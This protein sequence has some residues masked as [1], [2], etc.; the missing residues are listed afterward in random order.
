[1]RTFWGD[2]YE[3]MPRGGRVRLHVSISS[4]RARTLVMCAAFGLLVF[5]SAEVAAAPNLTFKDRL[6]AQ[7]T[8]ER[9][10]HAHMLG[11]PSS[12]HEIYPPTLTE[13]R[14]RDYLR[15]S[16][17]LQSYWG[18]PVDA[19][20]LEREMERIAGATRMPER[21]EEVYTALGNN[22]VLIQE[23]FIR[24]LV[25][26]RLARSFF[27]RDR[28]IHAEEL[29]T[30]EALRSRLLDGSIDP[31]T[32]R[33]DR[34]LIELNLASEPSSAPG[35]STDEEMP[36][37]EESGAWRIHLDNDAFAER[38]AQFVMPEGAPGPIE[39]SDESFVVRVVLER[40][41]DH[42]LVAVYT[43]AKRSWDDW[44]TEVA[45]GLDEKGVGVAAAPYAT[46]IRPYSVPHPEQGASAPA[47]DAP[48]DNIWDN[49][50][51][52][53][54][55]SGRRLNVAVWTGTYLIVWGGFGTQ[56]IRADGARYDPATDTWSQISQVGAPGARAQFSAVWSGREMIIW[57]GIGS[58]F[59]SSFLNSGGRYDPQTD[60]WRPTQLAGA[61]S[62]RRYQSAV[63]TGDRMIVWGGG[64]G[65]DNRL[66]SGG[67]YDPVADAWTPTTLT[68]APEGRLWHSAVW[69][70]TEMMVWGGVGNGLLRYGMDTGGLYN[71]TTNTWR[72]TSVEGAP[73][74]RY[75]H[76]AVWSGSRVLIWG[77]DG[78]FRSGGRYDP[79]R[80]LWEP[81]S[82]DDAPDGSA[83]HSAVWVG[84]A[85][86]VWGASYGSNAGARYDVD[87][88]RWSPISDE[89]APM[90]RGGHAAVWTGSLMLIWGGENIWS[91]LDTGGRYDPKADSWTPISTA[92]N[93]P[94]RSRYSAVWTG[95]EMIIW[96][97]RTADAHYT[98]TGHRY[99][100]ISDI[101]T[102]IA[103][104]GAPS[105]RAG[106]GAVWIGDSMVVW[107]G[108]GSNPIEAG[109][110]Y[111]P[112]SDRWIPVS[113]VGAPVSSLVTSLF[114]TGKEMI[115]WGTLYDQSGSAGGLYSPSTDTWRS[116]SSDGGPSALVSPSTVWTGHD[117]L[118]WGRD[119]NSLDPHGWSYHLNSD[120][121]RPMSETDQPST[122]VVATSIWTG[123]EMVIW[124]GDAYGGT[125]PLDTGA[126]YDPHTDHWRP[127]STTSAPSARTSP[128]AVWTGRR[129]MVW[130]GSNRGLLNTGGLYDPKTDTWTA[131]A[132]LDAPTG[133]G[134]FSAVWSGQH[135]LIWGGTDAGG[136]G[137]RYLISQSNRP[138]IANAG[139]DTSYEC[140]SYAGAPVSIDGTAS[141]DEDST[142]G[143]NDDILTY[144]W[145]EHWGEPA[146]RLVSE[147]P[148]ATLALTVGIHR[149]TLQVTD[150]L[151]AR[152][153]DDRVVVIRDTSPPTLSVEAESTIL[154]PPNHDLVPIQ[155]AV[156]VHDICDPM[157]AVRLG[158]AVSS[159]PD[160][161]PSP[162][163]GQTT[164]DII[165][166]D[167]VYLRAERDGRGD[168]RT[169]TL[170]YLATDSEGNT[171][172]AATTVTVPHDMSAPP[173]LATT[174][175]R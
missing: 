153:T 147:D 161:A 81:M 88:D 105:G 84:D 50:S 87:S 14:V 64:D 116:I 89:N 65:F 45:P 1:M 137:G 130:G 151:G 6:A 154:W 142:E 118:V 162:T 136:N 8:L 134:G 168:G 165:L 12:F 132:L 17:A 175:A 68:G 85:M 145:F 126:R 163:D 40:G 5:R 124:G 32:A 152:A 173:S 71:P 67:A 128:S 138:P 52:G 56:G 98:A 111:Y 47:A 10:S 62:G 46:L 131:T 28:R 146:Q 94:A 20:M 58:G 53:V 19:R 51:F 69:T 107:G 41:A 160:D 44:W 16:A 30:A 27:V 92:G 101:W 93:P 25:V 11:Q 83:G 141:S 15:M 110:R 171:A 38:S 35:A 39:E 37:F 129:M 54:V 63:W 108:Y 166:G 112:A 79:S 159:E 49:G 42:V 167:P 172:T 59:G 48:A 21:I 100:P 55:P 103:T 3:V 91:A 33:A 104:I 169:Y 73:Y 158:S 60:Q 120:E 72:R 121:W 113:Q 102:P 106:A 155:V 156:T 22:P 66:A 135:V 143:T 119:D 70:G 18:T 97:G 144:E 95:N 80:D 23:C 78:G 43:I 90:G 170:R 34:M 123:R 148:Q 133:R 7:E 77:G 61:P 149:L 13:A 29:A 31:H 150:Y 26:Q 74:P 76:T 117:F 127:M 82:T 139:P 157:P 4:L 125:N 96:G 75:M 9:I 122:R 174:L 99:D 57:G 24:P 36:R 109:G 164:G 114:W 86:I 2:R 115:A 140:V